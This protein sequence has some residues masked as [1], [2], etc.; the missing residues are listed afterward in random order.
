M[1]TGLS[2]SWNSEL[3]CDSSHITARF[4]FHQ[5]PQVE[6]Q[7]S[8]SFISSRLAGI[9]CR[10]MTAME[11][12]PVCVFAAMSVPIPASFGSKQRSP[13][14]EDFLSGSDW[15]LGNLSHGY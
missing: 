14:K 3:D 9:P 2:Q 10:L 13:G 6:A 1:T 11:K 5:H 15:Q 4:N 12:E 8:S 7:T